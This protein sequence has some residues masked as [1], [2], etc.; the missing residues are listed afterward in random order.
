MPDAI[1]A[2]D[3][4]TRKIGVAIG[5]RET[6]MAHPLAVIFYRKKALLLSEI[7]KIIAEWRPRLLLMGAPSHQDGT[8]HPIAEQAKLLAR[9]ITKHFS[10]QTILVD[11]RLTTMTAKSQLD[12]MGLSHAKQ[13]NAADSVAACE[14]IRGYLSACI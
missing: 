8:P 6:A 2:I 13:K 3:Y 9:D 7:G 14:I 12:E 1:L 10:L 5:Y 4:G 11:E